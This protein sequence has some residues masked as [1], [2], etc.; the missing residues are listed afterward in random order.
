M[1]KEFRA[2]LKIKA[3]R[4]AKARDSQIAGQLAILEIKR[5]IDLDLMTHALLD[6]LGAPAIYEGERLEA[7]ARLSYLIG[8]YRLIE[9]IGK[10]KKDG[11]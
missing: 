8:R 2:H 4:L 3:E 5:L 1:D 11:R 9:L 6:E 7:F 10:E